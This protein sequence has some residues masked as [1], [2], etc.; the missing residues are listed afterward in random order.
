MN[1]LFSNLRFEGDGQIL[2]SMN[3]LENYAI[4]AV[5]G[6]IGQV[7]DF[8]F[9]DESW[10]IRCVET[11]PQPSHHGRQEMDARHALH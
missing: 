7:K 3:D 8:Y 11:R 10:V 9:D 6:N 1:Q 4:R 5:D 2:R